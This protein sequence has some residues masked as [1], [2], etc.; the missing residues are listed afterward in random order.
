MGENIKVNIKMIKNMEWV[1]STG[2][3]VVN[4]L[5]NGKMVSNME[6]ENTTFKTEKK[7]QD[8]G[9]KEKE[10]NGYNKIK[11]KI[12]KIKSDH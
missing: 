5:D 7:K 8:N 3:M 6:E 11:I 10:L 4:I 12:T 9:F 2:Q 1:H